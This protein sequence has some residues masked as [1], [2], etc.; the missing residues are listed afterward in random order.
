MGFRSRVCLNL[1][2]GKPKFNI[3][4]FVNVFSLNFIYTVLKSTLKVTRDVFRNLFY[5]T[6]KFFFFF[7]WDSND[8]GNLTDQIIEDVYEALSGKISRDVILG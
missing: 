2:I 4:F 7:R 1:Q 5:D 6:T 3:L 8:N